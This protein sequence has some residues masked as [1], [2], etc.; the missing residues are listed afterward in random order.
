[1]GG[2]VIAVGACGGEPEAARSAPPALA[3][4]TTPADLG[5]LATGL[6]PAADDTPPAD[7]VVTPVRTARSAGWRDAPPALV[8]V[9]ER[10]PGA[11]RFCYTEFGQKT[12]PR[13][14]G[15]VALG[16]TVGAAGVEAVRVAASQWVGGAGGA[17][18][19]CLLERAPLA[20]RVAPGAVLAGRY[21]VE[22]RF[23]PSS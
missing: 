15:A 12:A 19:Q 7:S 1:M 2:V 4:D 18:E 23:E 10:E 9:V 22:L 8:E 16:V 13:L 20:W 5:A 14:A 6:P 3:A 11:L 17:V 21:V